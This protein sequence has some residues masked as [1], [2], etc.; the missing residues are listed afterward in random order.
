MKFQILHR[1]R[2]KDTIIL[3]GNFQA[4]VTKPLFFPLA[5]IEFSHSLWSCTHEDTV[6]YSIYFINT[7]VLISTAQLT[8]KHYGYRHQRQVKSILTQPWKMFNQRSFEKRSP[9]T[10]FS[11]VSS[12]GICCLTESFIG[13]VRSEKFLV[14]K[15]VLNILEFF[16]NKL[17]NPLTIRCQDIY[18]VVCVF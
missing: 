8:F 11:T 18:L 6:I 13:D 9:E 2:F 1:S 16:F 7:S 4:D 5:S 10:C 12:I 3:N 17:S 14:V 15:S